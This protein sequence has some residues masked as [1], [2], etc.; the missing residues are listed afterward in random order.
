MSG[1]EIT[2]YDIAKALKI[3]PSTV[4]RALND[5]KVVNEKTRKK[6]I[7]YAEK[8]G[9]QANTFASNLRNQE[10]KTIGVIV[11]KLDSNF[12]AKCLAGAEKVAAAKGYNLLISQSFEEKEKEIAIAKTMF[13]KRIDGLL[14]SLALDSDNAEHFKPFIDKGIPVLFFDRTPNGIDCPIYAIDNYT[15]SILATQHLIKQH[16]KNIA[17]LT[18]ETSCAVYVDR[19]R[20]FNSALLNNDKVSGSIIYVDKLEFE[21]G[22]YAAEIISKQKH[23]PDG[24]FAANDQLA[25]GCIVGLKK[26]GFDIPNDI[27]I[28]GFNNDLACKMTSPELTSV[29]Y[30][31]FDLGNIMTNHLVEHILGNSNIYQTNTTLLKTKLVI[32]QSS[33]R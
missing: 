5:S 9:Y 13:K 24:I 15:T 3:S 32:R 23:K 6:V 31:A 10:T 29:D 11:P 33:L 16:C 30:P 22:I 7:D 28:V 12:I 18:V 17:H 1:T 27:A 26:A 21:A 14:V 25:L 20:G 4:S 8:M 19:Q 2:I